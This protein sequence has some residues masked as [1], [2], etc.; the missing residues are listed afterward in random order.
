[1]SD[2]QAQAKRVEKEELKNFEPAKKTH[3]LTAEQRMQR[4]D[5]LKK[6]MVLGNSYKSKCS[7]VFEDAEGLK[8]VETT[9]W[10]ANELHIVLKGGI[11]LPISSIRDVIV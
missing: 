7:I 5:N 9:I 1:M 8:N 6:A 4:L 11:V 10:M 2:G 3:V